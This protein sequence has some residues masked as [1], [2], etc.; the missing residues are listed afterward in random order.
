MC[1]N[2]DAGVSRPT[3]HVNQ[4]I[5]RPSQDGSIGPFTANFITHVLT[6]AMVAD[7]KI[8]LMGI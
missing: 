8:S 6:F 2:I 4:L 3:H 7:E 5:K 1:N